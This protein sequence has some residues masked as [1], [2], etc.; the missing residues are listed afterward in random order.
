MSKVLPGATRRSLHWL[1]VPTGAGHHHE[2]ALVCINACRPKHELGPRQRASA[3]I[4]RT[5]TTMHDLAILAGRAP[6]VLESSHDMLARS[7]VRDVVDASFFFQQRPTHTHVPSLICK[8]FY[9]P[10]IFISSSA[11]AFSSLSTPNLQTERLET[12]RM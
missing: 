7:A 9:R 5:A 3:P 10:W 2:H 4:C 6:F 12:W 1:Q 11:S 8:L